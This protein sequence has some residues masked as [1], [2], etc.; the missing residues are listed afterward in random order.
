MRL[1]VALLAV[2]LAAPA[3]AQT[4]ASEQSAHRLSLWG[5]VIPVAAGV[6]WWAAHG[7]QT[8]SASTSPDLPAGPGLLMAGGLIVGPTLGYSTAG[9][10][11]RG[12]RG[13]GIRSG[14]TLL[15]FVPAMAICGWDCRSGGQGS[16]SRVAHHRDGGRPQPR[17]RHLRHLAPQTEYEATQRDASRARALDRAPVHTGAA[18]L[19]GQPRTDVL[20][21]SHV[22]GVG[23]DGTSAPLSRTASRPPSPR[24]R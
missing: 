5:T 3:A 21:R 12:W 16:R 20:V 6:T 19:R 10:N 8:G 9:L 18:V 17:L 4:V 11:G 13:A 1:A 14:L 7:L 22:R 15:S 24:R 23:W 2:V